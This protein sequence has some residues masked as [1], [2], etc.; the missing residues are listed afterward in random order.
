M[1]TKKRCIQITQRKCSWPLGGVQQ[2]DFQFH[3]ARDQMR[4]FFGNALLKYCKRG[5]PNVK[6][7]TNLFM[8]SLY[9]TSE[10]AKWTAPSF[11][12]DFAQNSVPSSEA[13]ARL[14]QAVYVILCDIWS[15]VCELRHCNS[16]KTCRMW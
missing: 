5:G 14:Q 4:G 15:R 3:G 1:Q 8:L 10:S 2:L 6:M 12:T 16:Q 9:C 13:R 11:Q 7:N